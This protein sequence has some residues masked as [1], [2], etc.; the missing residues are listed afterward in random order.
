MSSGENNGR[1]ESSPGNP[2]PQSPPASAEIVVSPTGSPVLP[3]DIPVTDNAPTIISKAGQ[4]HLRPEE[5]LASSVKGFRLAHFELL[6]PIGAGGMAAVIRAHDLQLDRMV[7]LK[8][9]PRD[10]VANPE[11]VRRFHQEARAAAKLDHEN[12]A[13]VF[14]CGEDQGTHFIAFEFVEG[15]NLRA[16]IER[17]GKVPVAE[18]IGYMLQIALGLAHAAERGVVHRDIKPS[19]IIISPNGRAKLVDMGLARSLDPQQDGGLT[20]SGITLGT[21][22]YISPEQALEPREADVCS[23]IYSLGCTFY[24]VLTGQPSVPEGTAAK[25]LHHH[26]HVDPVDP[27]QLNPEIPDDVAALLSRM[28]AK[29]RA[30]RYQRPEDLVRHLYALARKLGAVVEIPDRALLVEPPLPAPPRVRPLTLALFGAVALVAF[31]LLQSPGSWPA[32]MNSGSSDGPEGAVPRNQPTAPPPLADRLPAASD[33]WDDRGSPEPQP[34]EPFFARDARGLAD[35]LSSAESGTVRIV[36]DID[37]TRESLLKF[38]GRDLIIESAEP[39]RLPTIRLQY[40][41]EHATE[42]GWS[43]LTI[44]A[45]GNVHIRGIRFEL[46]AHQADIDMAAL[47]LESGRLQVD[48]CEFKQVRPAGPEIGHVSSVTVRGPSSGGDKPGFVARSSCFTLGQF[49]VRLLGET[50]FISSQCV[51]GPHSASL[52]DMEQGGR[53]PSNSSMLVSMASCSALLSGAPVFRL[54]GGGRRVLDISNCIFS[55]LDS[56]AGASSAG[57]LLEE[58]GDLGA[59]VQFTGFHNCYHNLKSIWMRSVG[60]EIAD[61]VD[62]LER[63]RQQIWANDER[64]VQLVESPWENPDPLKLW[65]QT[66]KKALRISPA[67][68]ELRLI[69]DPSRAI[70]VEQSLWGKIYDRPLPPLATRDTETAA[71]SN[72]KIVDPRALTAGPRVYRTIRLALEEAAPGD[73]IQ[74]KHT[75][76]LRMEPVQLEKS[77]LDITIRPFP[78][79]HPI[80]TCGQTTEPDSALFRLHDGQLTLD[81]LEFRIAPGREQFKSQAV[82]ALMGDGQCVFKDCVA[83]LEENSYASL[84]MTVLADSSEV[85]KM[86]PQS[87][88]RQDP[89]LSFQNCFVRGM[90]NLVTVR[91][92]R[93]FQLRAEQCLLAL[94]GSFLT[95]D[96]NLRE[97][98]TRLHAE[99]Y[100]K[101]VTT[102]LTESL[103]T[104]RAF[105]D[106][107]RNSKGLVSTQIKTATDCL[108]VAAGNKALVHLEGIDSDDQMRSYLSWE[109]SRRNTYSNYPQLLEFQPWAERNMMAPPP[110]G[111]RQWEGFT[112]ETDSRYEHV[113]FPVFAGGDSLLSHASQLSF[114]LRPVA[115]LPDCGADIEHLPHVRDESTSSAGTI[116]TGQ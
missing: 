92:S 97:P 32:A 112:R 24:H 70:G 25:K 6:E 105:R 13:R 50:T 68:P 100:L 21:F 114:K 27:R 76:L 23:D 78:G 109:D 98:S 61:S 5:A 75:G 51:F 49:A 55:R 28:M 64:S 101:K 4:P 29:H 48:N 110:Y 83:S 93:P 104:L 26:Q 81:G 2:A 9:L 54:E 7:A 19:N 99:I 88:V 56:S 84:S 46:D 47:V 73:E 111:Q 3:T 40:D 106:L 59:D 35:F 36:N 102:Y 22:D 63:F 15:E 31:I 38:S 60:R 91:A 66:P 113:H 57:T 14:F 74:I 10:M 72:I 71:A 45:S 11:I 107:T 52:V 67:Q 69:G 20:H 30:D 90:G 16:L 80:L 86:N 37:L 53:P 8:I 44:R 42:D 115:G 94:D 1:D 18:A 17:R 58:T 79:F 77:G 108:F 96:G 41:L 116:N 89:R 33:R 62:D 85:I 95:M 43:A 65:A 82:L 39:G 87:S 103:L 34:E 12:I